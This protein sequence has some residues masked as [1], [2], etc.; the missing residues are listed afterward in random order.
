[1]IKTDLLIELKPFLDILARV[2]RFEKETNYNKF[3]SILFFVGLIT[4]IGGWIEYMLHHFLDINVTFLFFNILG[5]FLIAIST[6]VYIYKGKKQQ[7][8]Y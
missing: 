6:I 5:L 3:W 7:P 4:I 1:M 2:E 8:F